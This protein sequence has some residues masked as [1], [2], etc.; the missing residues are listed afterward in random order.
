MVAAFRL[1]QRKYEISLEYLVPKARKCSRKEKGHVTGH[2]SKGHVL[3]T[4]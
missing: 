1:G 3:V 4:L 2:S